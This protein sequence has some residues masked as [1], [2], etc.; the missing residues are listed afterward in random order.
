MKK[1]YISLINLLARK[2]T[3]TMSFED[4][5]LFFVNLR[6][7]MRREAADAAAVKAQRNKERYAKARYTVIHGGRTM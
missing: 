7:A 3:K 1:I 2:L 6:T 4:A 5:D